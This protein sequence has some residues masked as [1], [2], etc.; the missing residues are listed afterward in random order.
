[1]SLWLAADV[2]VLD[3][4]GNPCVNGST[5]VTW[6]D[7]SGNA[8]NAVGTATFQ[9]N[10]I[11]GFPSVSFNGSNTNAVITNNTITPTNAMFVANISSSGQG[12]WAVLL[13]INTG[14][15]NA[16]I[17]RINSSNSGQWGSDFNNLLMPVSQNGVAN[18]SITDNAFAQYSAAT[19]PG[20][21]DTV[22]SGRIG[23]GETFSRPIK[24]LI[25]E[26]LIY[27]STLTAAQITQTQNYLMAKWI[28]P[29]SLF[30]DGEAA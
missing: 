30:F 3:A 20:Y 25:S 28:N 2:G 23:I 7:Q 5:V 10:A 12:V 8:N 4:S 26:V 11:H 18:G 9:T 19:N 21:S 15:D 29:P 27:S 22:F 16:Y 6:L 1:M 13:G 17:A 14:G 24:A